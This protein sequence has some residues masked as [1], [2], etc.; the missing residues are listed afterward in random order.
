MRIFF[1]IRNDFG[2][3][4]ELDERFGRAPMFLIY[5]LNN[6]KIVQV[7]KNPFLAQEHGVGIRVA[8]YLIQNNCRIAVGSKF[9]PKAESVL[10]TGDVKMLRVGGGAV[11]NVIDK[12]SNSIE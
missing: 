11:K 9:G 10:R 4:S 6:Q 7:E 5:D 1:T 3:D 2:L 8:N 12:I